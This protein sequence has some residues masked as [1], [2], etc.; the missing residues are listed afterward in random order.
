MR[1]LLNRFIHY[2]ILH[3]KSALPTAVMAGILAGIL[4]AIYRAV[5]FDFFK[6]TLFATGT[7][8]YSILG[9]LLALVYIA[10][11]ILFT[12]LTGR[13]I[14]GQFIA[15]L[16]FASVFNGMVTPW[17]STLIMDYLNLSGQLIG[18]SRFVF[19]SVLIIIMQAAGIGIYFIIERFLNLIRVNIRIAGFALP[20]ILLILMI[21]SFSFG[22]GSSY[23]VEKYE[24]PADISSRKMPNV[25]FII[26]DCL[27]YDTVSMTNSGMATPNMRKLAEDGI[28]YT[29]CFTQCSWTKPSIASMYT[30][31][32]TTQ[33]NVKGLGQIINPDLYTLPKLMSDEGYFAVGFSNN[34][35]IRAV[36]NFHLGFNYF[37]YLHPSRVIPSDPEAPEFHFLI[38]LHDYL[39]RLIV[40]K[41]ELVSFYYRNANYTSKRVIDWLDK[42]SDKN[43]YM[44][45]HYMDPHNPY[46]NHP[47][48]GEYYVP[49]PDNYSEEIEKKF[50]DTYKKEVEYTDKALGLLFEH[51]KSTGIY[52]NTMIVLT[53]DHGDEFH[54]HGGWD[55]GHSLYDELIH[56]PLIIKL[57]HSELKGTVD[58]SLVETID[59]PPTIAGYIGAGEV[60]EWQGIDIFSG[61]NRDWSFSEVKRYGVH[62]KSLRSRTEKLYITGLN[63]DP[64]IEYYD[65]AQDKSESNN[66]SG[67]EDLKP[68]IAELLKTLAEF[69]DNLRE[70]AVEA[71]SHTLDRKTI[72]QLRQL[73][74]IK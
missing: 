74:Y 26:L 1:Y 60:P 13:Y 22:I 71:G 53:S 25:I 44:F 48:D 34:V 43:F 57:A 45:L 17:L 52:D 66:L 33:H 16:S 15:Y 67:N 7:F 6:I 63:A 68:R 30:S 5:S 2:V 27:R 37:E 58:S 28:F 50:F 8:Y 56:A 35:M 12:F 46:F 72:E 61:N 73:G 62:A 54:E 21:I 55:H 70:K 32:Y 24:P 11:V 14:R 29:N 42:N 69:E 51:L 59:I 20:V 41:T 18:N 19:I 40:D 65:I 3:L 64:V 4:E 31:L 47:Y 10:P 49:P 36:A 39:K 9:L 23:N 38:I